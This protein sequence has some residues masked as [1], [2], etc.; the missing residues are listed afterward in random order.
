MSADVEALTIG[1]G[2][3]V[4]M[5]FTITLEDGTVADTSREGEPLTFTMG[6][7]SL[8][9][10]LELALY[11]LKA[12][13]RQVVTMDP[14]EAFGFPDPDNVHRLPRGEFPA[15]MPPE[16]GQIVSFSTPSGEEIPG[17]IVE[18]GEDEV[19]VDFNHPLAGH[20]I[21]FDTEIIAIQPPAGTNDET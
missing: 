18:V 13:D 6:D 3:R 10:G 17:A 5:H 9:E 19:T 7:G 11:G 8:I 15:D 14:R 4:T 2:C 16:E 21:V 20:E 1:P 12:G